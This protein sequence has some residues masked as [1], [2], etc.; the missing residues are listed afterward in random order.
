MD[1][2]AHSRL[3]VDAEMM[4]TRAVHTNATAWGG[5]AYVY[6]QQLC[7]RTNLK[8]NGADGVKN[9]VEEKRGKGLVP[10]VQKVSCNPRVQQKAE[11]AQQHNK[12]G[13]LHNPLWQ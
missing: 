11:V 5:M 13:Q 6:K 1:S 2:T 12:R 8:Q 9:K 7:W 10:R 4:Y 3:M